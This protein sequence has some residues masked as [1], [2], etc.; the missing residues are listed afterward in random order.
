M[1]LE[2]RTH[3]K[4]GE[5]VIALINVVFLILIFIMVTTVIE[6]ID[7]LAVRLAEGE[8][9]LADVKNAEIV[10]GADG[11]LAFAQETIELQSLL[12]HLADQDINKVSL[13]ADAELKTATLF[14][15]VAALEARGI[16]HI[17]LATAR[18]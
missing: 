5:P 8:T 15:I 12:Q 2:S 9:D 13:R 3:R 11:R 10:I 6:P 18:P 17:D 1:R 4:R 16:E 7:P 14:S